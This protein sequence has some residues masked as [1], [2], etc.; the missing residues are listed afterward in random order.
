MAARKVG[1]SGKVYGVDMT[2]EM[3]NKA[4]AYAEREGYHN[5]EFLLGEIE[6]L[7]LANIVISI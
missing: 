6:H 4:R 2:H 5:V 7:P 3:L 1:D